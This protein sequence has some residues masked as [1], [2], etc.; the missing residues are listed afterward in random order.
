MI[1]ETTTTLPPAEVLAAAKRFFTRRNPIYGS[2]LDKQGD[3]FVTFRGQ[4]GEE[5]VIGVQRIE[6]GTAV[7]GSTYLFDQQ[8]SRF[9]TTLPPYPVKPEAVIV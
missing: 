2:F 3:S 6:G 8:I 7:R 9:F 5:V 1:L 4:G